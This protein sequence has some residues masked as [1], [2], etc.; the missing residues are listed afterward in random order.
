[1]MARVGI[2]AIG[3]RFARLTD[4]RIERA[5]RHLLSDMVVIALCAAIC[6]ADS[7]ADVGRFGT[8]KLDWLL[9]FRELAEVTKRY[10]IAAAA[11]NL[12]RIMRLPFG[13]GKPRV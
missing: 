3:E 2:V 10:R 9:R 1:F 7:W 13:I 12:G 11:H 8:S 4:P 6:G 5:K